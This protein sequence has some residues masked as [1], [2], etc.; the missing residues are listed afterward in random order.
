MKKR[1]RRR[2]ISESLL[3]QF[4]NLEP[5]LSESE[6][7]RKWWG[8]L[9]CMSCA[10]CCHS[11]F[12]PIKM[13]DAVSFYER[14]NISMSKAW[15]LDKFLQKSELDRAT[16]SIEL[17]S[18]GGKCLFLKKLDDRLFACDKWDDRPDICKDFLC[19]PMNRFAL[20]N[21]DQDQDMFDED[22]DWE[23]NYKILFDKVLEEMTGALFADDMFYF[24]K[25]Q[26]AGK[27]NSSFEEFQDGGS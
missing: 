19:W 21:N 24:H 22:L 27:F 11:S 8:S 23:S 20:Y 2:K 6:V 3:K 10:G 7:L 25:N 15:F 13:E 9:V 16:C 18:H 4:C 14:L 17:R 5:S 12:I 26:T 1:N